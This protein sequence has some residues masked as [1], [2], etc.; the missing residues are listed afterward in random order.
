MTRR[1]KEK[2]RSQRWSVGKKKTVR[3]ARKAIAQE[4]EIIFIR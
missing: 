2:C 4:I 1:K 3:L